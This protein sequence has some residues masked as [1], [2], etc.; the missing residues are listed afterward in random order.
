[1]EMDSDTLRPSHRDPDPDPDPEKT[2]DAPGVL[3][4][5]QEALLNRAERKVDL[6]LAPNL[7]GLYVFSLVDRNNFGGARVAGLDEATDLQVSN[8][9]S[10]ASMLFYVG[11]II[12][13]LP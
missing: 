12:L 7:G 13:K 2:D 3:P 4:L 11:Y 1:M 9:S 6:R 10:I 5:E 8:R